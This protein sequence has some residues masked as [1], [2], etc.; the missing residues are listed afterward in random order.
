MTIP[1][2]TLT[3]IDSDHEVSNQKVDINDTLGDDSILNK[4]ERKARKTLAKLGLKKVL[5]INRV[6]MRKFKSQQFF[7]IAN[8]EVFKSATANVYI[9]FGEAKTEETA[10]GLNLGGGGGGGGGFGAESM[11]SAG[12]QVAGKI[13]DVNEDDQEPADET[14]I[15]PSDIET[16]MTQVNCSR[17]KAV[18]ALK[19]NDGDLINAIISAS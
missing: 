17:N 15:D 12:K 8:A 6:T 5:G 18:K 3:E 4:S 14:G 9:V 11:V 7:V 2:S 19:E 16:V 10:P 13:T 1:P